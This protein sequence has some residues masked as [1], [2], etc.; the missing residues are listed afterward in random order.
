MEEIERLKK[1]LELT[2]SVLKFEQDRNKRLTNTNRE[3]TKQ[4]S[5]CSVSQQSELVCTLHRYCEYQTGLG[6][7]S[8][9]SQCDYKKQTCG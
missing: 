2:E 5:L 7:C 6:K 1:G 9:L 8:Y 4:L 3:L